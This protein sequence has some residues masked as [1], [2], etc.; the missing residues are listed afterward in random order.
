MDWKSAVNLCGTTGLGTVDYGC[1]IQIKIN[2][3]A[4]LN[5]M[6]ASINFFLLRLSHFF[7]RPGSI[8]GVN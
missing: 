3:L 6:V 4:E 5:E 2:L 7:E 1:Q 8:G